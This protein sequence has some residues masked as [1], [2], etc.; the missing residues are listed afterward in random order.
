MVPRTTFDAFEVSS[1]EEH[2]VGQTKTELFEE[3]CRAHRETL[4]R[5]AMA[6]TQDLDD[7][8]DLLQ[9]TLLRAYLHF[10]KFQPGTNFRAWIHRIM[11]NLY[12]NE[13]NKRQ[14][15][16]QICSLEEVPPEEW[17]LCCGG[18]MEPEEIFLATIQDDR[19]ERAIAELPEGFRQV[20][21]LADVKG[22]SYAEVSRRLNIPIGTVRSRLFRARRL[23]R[24]KLREYAV[25]SGW[26][27]P[28]NGIE[29]SSD[30]EP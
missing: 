9:D 13:Y 30:P 8:E 3:L 23:L 6:L 7:A 14:R 21:V 17:S 25:Q 29:T 28:R 5:L 26:I 27:R 19:I 1:V 2:R 10:D 11:V 18:T 16:P 12:I 20:V 15:R 4:L 24:E 22:Y